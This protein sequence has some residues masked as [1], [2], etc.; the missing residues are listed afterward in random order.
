ML[1]CYTQ[2]LKPSYISN[3]WGYNDLKRKSVI[4]IKQP[5]CLIIT[6]QMWIVKTKNVCTPYNV[7]KTL[8]Y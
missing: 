6:N 2:V 1:F 5:M 8:K 3:V 4:V 7:E